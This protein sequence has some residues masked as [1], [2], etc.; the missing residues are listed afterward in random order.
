[1]KPVRPGRTPA[2]A[3]GRRAL[4]LGFAAAAAASPLSTRGQQRP[5]LARIG[6]LFFGPP[7]PTGLDTG[8]AGLHKGLRELGYV[9]GRNFVLER[10]YANGRPERLDALA[11][12]LVRMKVDVILTGGPPPREAASRATRTI[13]IVTVS[14]ADPVREGWAK[15]LARPGGNITGMTV[16][17]PELD[18]KRLEILKQAFPHVVRVA[19]LIHPGE[20]LDVAESLRV[21]HEGARQL[22]LELQIVEVRSADG[23]DAAIAQTRQRQAQAMY[24]IATNTLLE[25]RA[26]LAALAAGDRM[27]SVSE[28]SLMAQAGFLFVYGA[29]LEDLTQRAAAQIDKIL[30][31]TPAGDLP[32]ERPTKFLLTVNTK[33]AKA[34]GIS[35]PAALL[36]RADAVIS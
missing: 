11:S 16:T 14:G 2:G 34:I 21:M 23:I 29:D 36:A 13:P 7:A 6:I 20:L 35:M 25:N 22:G 10:R 33:A 26:R 15:S 4:L 8:M 9:E 24:V 17:Y 3:A 5:G 12:E 31:G 18:L 1:M 30:K 19:V 32:I 28:L 27:I